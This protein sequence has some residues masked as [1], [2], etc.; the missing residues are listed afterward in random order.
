MGFLTM[1]NKKIL[2]IDGDIAVTKQI[3]EELNPYGY[4]VLCC[5]T[6]QDGLATAQSAPIDLAIIAVE[7]SDDN[8]FVTCAKLKKNPKT[9]DLPVFITSSAGS[10]TA[11]EQH[12]QLP[13]HADGYFL[14]P[15]DMVTL[16][17][18]MT[19]IFAE[20]DAYNAQLAASQAS[21]AQANMDDEMID[22]AV[23]GNEQPAVDDSEVLRAIDIEGEFGE[24]DV[25]DEE[26]FGFDAD[27]MDMV[28][29]DENID[30]ALASD[31]AVESDDTQAPAEAPAPQAEP[32]P[33][34][35]AAPVATPASKFKSAAP[36][37]SIAPVGKPVSPIGRPSVAPVPNR[38]GLP[39]VKP[40]N[41]MP[42][43][44]NLP[45]VGGVA[46]P[47]VSSQPG[48]PSVGSS[49]VSIT[50]VELSSMKAEI[51]SLKAELAG[52]DAQLAAQIAAKD[53]EL[54]EKDA[55]IQ[56]LVDQAN[57]YAD[58]INEYANQAND[59]A[60]QANQFADQANDLQDQVKEL[61]DEV[62]NLKQR[63]EAADQTIQ[64]LKEAASS[65]VADVEAMNR[66]KE[67]KNAQLRAIVDQLNA[68]INE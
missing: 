51:A 11:F 53:S 12:S 55:Q 4:E 8:G 9:R 33:V 49:A 26:G 44:N 52:K 61:T 40:I 16:I 13:I 14:K 1:S 43:R 63:L 17:Q 28:V 68:I 45:P 10:T 47:A 35:A 65:S 3:T 60:G 22:V 24:I 23:E 42:S 62:S 57:A 27:E 2:I 54:A 56:Q 34:S 20:I 67:E 21:E 46:R 29:M 38:N 32:A 48:I 5:R 7:L 30:D 41:R 58:R 66:V 59:Y 15:I 6:E 19:D 37:S 50:N 36:L 64:Q 39:S 18:N 25:S 31:A